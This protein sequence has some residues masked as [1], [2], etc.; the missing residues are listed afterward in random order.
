MTVRRSWRGG[1]GSHTISS[2]STAAAGTG[3]LLGCCRARIGCP[4]AASAIAATCLAP[5][6][7]P[8]TALLAASPVGSVLALARP[9]DVAAT[10]HI[11][12]TPGSPSSCNPP[13]GDVGPAIEGSPIVG[14][15]GPTV[16]DYSKV[17]ATRF[18]LVCARS[19]GRVTTIALQQATIR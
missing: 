17:G 1:V 14:L 19:A 16:V 3:A 8:H 13:P 10:P 2:T 18:A 9:L 7:G 11:S 15:V 6:G 12:S 5:I 4:S